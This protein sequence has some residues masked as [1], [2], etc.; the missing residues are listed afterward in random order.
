MTRLL[1]ALLGA[2]TLG[3]SA[4][5][6]PEQ[7][8]FPSADGQPI[9]ALLFRPAAAGRHPAVVALHGCG[10][11]FDRDGRL[12]ARHADWGERLAAAGFLVLMPDSF[13]SRGVG[14][15]CGMTGRVVR[16]GRERLGDAFAAKAYLQ[17]RPDVESRAV[18]LLGWSNGGTTLLHVT[19]A[20]ARDPFEGPGFAKAVA[21]YPGCRIPAERG[22]HAAIPVLILV[23][24]ADDW[25]GA[26]PCRGLAEA[27]R[28]EGSPVE[29]VVYPGAYHDFDAP[30]LPVR[31]RRGLAYTVNQDGV[32]H[33]GTD[34]AAREDALRRVPAFL[35]R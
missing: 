24:G 29:L 21:F 17:G 19:R 7:V 35:G 22:W 28:A 16:P 30:N 1:L 15:Q 2:L 9:Q 3:A 18:S 14:S 23:G 13:G 34:P 11:L 33:V 8:T 31:E 6:Q 4:A 10:G 5:A 25:T 26:E 12:N 32:A 27:A 20:G